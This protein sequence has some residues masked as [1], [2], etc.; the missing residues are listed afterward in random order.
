MRNARF[1][2]LAVA[3]VVMA[4]LSVAPSRAAA[5][6]AYRVI[7][8][9]ANPTTAVERRFLAEAFLKK[10]TRWPDGSLIRPVDQGGD[11]PSRQRFSEDILGRSI[12]AVRSYWQQMVFA[13]RNLPPPE[14]DSDD[15]VVRYVLK[16]GGA[17]GYVSGA[18]NVE[19]VK[20]MVVK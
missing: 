5:P 17:V 16:Y 2:L 4:A 11:A 14:L 1:R 7:V 15:E 13:G 6:V 3:L 10:T 20:T 9:P 8:N 12:A 19:R 18:A